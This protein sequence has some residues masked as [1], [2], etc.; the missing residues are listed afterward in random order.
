MTSG[1]ILL[2]ALAFA[3]WTGLLEQIPVHAARSA[4]V[5]VRVSPDLVWMAPL[6]DMLF[7]GVAALALLGLRRIW[8]RAGSRPVVLGTCAGLLTLA[9]ALLQERLHPLASLL[10][11]IGVGTQV[12]R[13]TRP[14]AHRPRFLPVAVAVAALL[15]AGATARSKWDAHAERG[16]AL[17]E[18]PEAPAGARNILLIILDT[19]RGA[20][21]GFLAAAGE[22]S[23]WPPALS[24]TLD[25]FVR[26]SV[27]FEDAVAASPWT[28]PSH[29]SMFTGQ[30]PDRL[31]ADWGRPLDRAYPTV[32]EVMERHGYR[33]VGVVANLLYASHET[34]LDR[35][36]LDYVDYPVSLGQTLLSSAF[37]RRLLADGRLRR[38]LTDE[39]LP[40]RF[41]AREVT[42]E[43]L[44]WQSRNGQRPFFGFVNYF[45]AHEPHF[46]PDS[47]RSRIPAGTKWNRYSYY[48]G[49]LTGVHARRAEKWTM[50]RD[51]AAVHAGAYNAAIH[52]ADREAGRLLEELDRRGVLENTVVI[53]ASDHGEQLGEHGLFEHQNSLY[54]TAVH[55]PLLVYDS[56]APERARRVAST[57]SLRDMGATIVDLAGLDVPSSG[58]SGRSLARFWEDGGEPD[59]Q[60]GQAPD[61]V[62]SVLSPRHEGQEWLPVGQGP[63]MYSLSDSNYHYILNVDGSEELYAVRQDPGESQDLAKAPA[64]REVLERLRAMMAGVRSKPPSG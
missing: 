41:T 4:G 1:R 62:F 60:S 17:A 27:L 38:V 8:P 2:T 51:E 31:S 45:D 11:A 32:A 54:R 14:V 10:L 53:L 33:T 15:I 6:A 13:M 59:A 5:F 49:L 35:G 52:Q 22:S 19:V 34:G 16:R 56:R 40:N 29:A 55:V 57:V 21:L 9:L 7:F 42:D 30:W 47:V 12:G 23:L 25:A 24:P 58:L 48:T 18:I 63:V 64:F 20:S 28:L 39:D 44:A 43:F 26:T 37:G 3:L 61:T 36:F 50:T 46:P